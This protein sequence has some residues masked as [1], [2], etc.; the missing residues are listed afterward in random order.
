MKNVCHAIKNVKLA[1]EVREI[2]TSAKQL[3]I[4]ELLQ[5]AN[6]KLITTIQVLNALPAIRYGGLFVFQ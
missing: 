6:V 4:E 3:I 5:L 1:P 2:V